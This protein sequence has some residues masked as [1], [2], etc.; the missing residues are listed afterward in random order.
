MIAPGQSILGPVVSA[1]G[2]NFGVYAP[3]A[4]K[5]MLCLFDSA[6]SE[7][8]LC[9]PGRTGDIHHGFVAG[10]VPGQRYGFR[11][12]GP[13]APEIGLRHDPS[14]LLID[15][16]ALAV[17]GQMTCSPPGVEVEVHSRPGLAG[18][19]SDGDAGHADGAIPD[20]CH[21]RGASHDAA[22]P[23]GVGWARGVD[24]ALF[25][26]RSVVVAHPA[27][28]F[29]TTSHAA[30]R[31][32]GALS[33]GGGGPGACSGGQPDCGSL[34][35]RPRIP[36]GETVIYETHVK[37][38]TVQ[39]PDV[40]PE[41]RGTYAGLATKPVVDHLLNLGVTTVELLPVQHFL[42]EPGLGRRGLTN[43]WGY[44]PIAFFAPH[45]GYSSRGDR[46]EQVDEF[47]QM[48]QTLHAAG[49][50]V[51]IDVVFNHTAEAGD[52]GMVLSLKGLA[53]RDS[54]LPED[55]AGGGY[56]NATGTG[57]TVAASN[58]A[59]L[60]LI[61]DGLRYWALAFD[62]DGFRFDLA[63]ALVR[64]WPGGEFGGVSPFLAVLGQDPVLSD[65]KLIAEPWDATADGY[66]LGGF[67]RPWREWNDRFRDD[68]R[69]YWRGQCGRATFAT[70]LAGSRDVY[71]VIP[72]EGSRSI[73]IVTTHDG[74][75]LADLVSY[76]QKHNE[77]NGEDG[78]D[79]ADHNHSW[80]G[81]IEGPTDNPAVR[82]D[83][84]RRQ[85]SLLITLLL[86]G[87]IPHILGGDELG[88][89]QLGNNNAYCQDNSTSWYDWSG[90]GG[91]APDRPMADG[92]DLPRLDG[93]QADSDLSTVLA[94]VIRLRREHPL[95]PI[96]DANLRRPAPAR[97]GQREQEIGSGEICW[98]ASDGSEL[99][100]EAW[101]SEDQRVACLITSTS[102]GQEAALVI[103][104]PTDN[105]AEWHVPEP[106]SGAWQ[107]AIP[108]GLESIESSG[109]G[110]N[111]VVPPWS[112]AVLVTQ[113]LRV[114]G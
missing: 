67:P 65:R 56:L 28:G 18:S 91:S 43:Y 105:A 88:R 94:H 60:Q 3:D 51:I 36:W 6:G 93:L 41:L 99:S 11:A 63:S 4:E 112:T 7:R 32:D 76:D 48:V 95:L 1:D 23:V 90:V 20:S 104:N 61:A 69:N 25:V 109:A 59:T 45:A 81:G 84:F 21:A 108:G 89:T 78:R 98:L 33:G 46:G 113:T 29:G 73:N 52:D 111:A 114:G 58:P 75:T 77:S 42:D 5:V 9:L 38:M 103:F 27:P 44:N 62:I 70:R 24:S 101:H 37:G 110:Q 97:F 17:T 71:P 26:P 54:Y 47:R 50:E 49:L 57:N 74:F 10:V 15:P 68:V 53:N 34:G 40:P 85:R 2:T 14:K 66:C 79:G 96:D 31:P 22:D 16:R 8:E 107:L 12:H 80:N 92:V 102:P 39:H 64:G 100:G 13:W 82:L 72:G 55:E 30:V 87:G 106:P 83:R 19:E 86:A 35:T